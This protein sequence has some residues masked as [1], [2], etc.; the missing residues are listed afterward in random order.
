[1]VCT[2][3]IRAFGS[4]CTSDSQCLTYISIHHASVGCFILLL[5]MP[6]LTSQGGPVQ[7]VQ[8][9]PTPGD[10]SVRIARV[11]CSSTAHALEAFTTLY[12]CLSLYDHP[13]LV[14]FWQLHSGEHHHGLTWVIAQ[15]Y[16]AYIKV[17]HQLCVNAT[18]QHVCAICLH[19]EKPQMPRQLSP[20]LHFDQ[21]TSVLLPGVNCGILLAHLKSAHIFSW[22]PHASVVQRCQD[23]AFARPFFPVILLHPRSGASCHVLTVTTKRISGQTRSVISCYGWSTWTSSSTRFLW[24]AVQCVRKVR[25][26]WSCGP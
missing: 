8:H 10:D 1:M 5:S 3:A 12:H 20:L 11:V 9:W 21:A 24:H 6:L 15:D 13:L 2:W 7:D 19:L 17:P 22:L 25:V 14:D 18:N 4:S 16:M 26:C 23:F